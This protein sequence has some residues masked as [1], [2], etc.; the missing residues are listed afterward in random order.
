M[1][2]NDTTS[3]VIDAVLKLTVTTSTLT[4]GLAI[5]NLLIA[6]E[7]PLNSFWKHMDKR[8]REREL[9]RV[10]SYM[11]SNQ[12][13][14]GDYEHGLQITDKGHR[15]L[16]EIE[17]ARLMVKP[18]PIWDG[19]WRLIIYDIPEEHKQGRNALTIK[20]N[21][22]G[23]HQLQRSAWIHPFP[24]RRV[25]EAVAARYKIDGYVSYI[26]TYRIDNQ[27]P[28]VQKFQKKYPRTSFK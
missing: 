7:K 5:P 16:A 10:V 19:A 28:I 13:L 27:K 6:M 24:C 22:L 3:A 20:L 1:A 15:R 2:R 21:E 25:I 18:K 12:L 4:A 8:Q 9:R 23:F 26:E 14:R 11:K 17:F